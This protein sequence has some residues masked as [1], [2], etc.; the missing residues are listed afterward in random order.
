MAAEKN[1]KENGKKAQIATPDQIENSIKELAMEAFTQTQQNG[2][3]GVVPKRKHGLVWERYGN[4]FHLNRDTPRDEK[5]DV[6]VYYLKK[7]MTG[8]YLEKQFDEYTFPYKIYGQEKKLLDRILRTY[9]NTNGNLG[10]IFN[11][12]RG[13]GKTVSAKQLCNMF[14]L[15]VILVNENLEGCHVYVNGIPQDIVVFIDE[16]EKIFE[17]ESEMLTIMDGSI[18]SVYRRTFLLTTN[19]LYVNDNLIQRPGRIRYVKTFKDLTPE[20]TEELIDDILI[21]KEFKEPLIRFIANLEM[22]TIDIVKAIIQEV[23]IHAEAPDEFADIFNVRRLTGKFNVFLVDKNKDDKDEEPIIRAIGSN[24]K[25]YDPLD[26][27]YSNNEG[28]SL[29]MNG[30]GNFHITKS[31]DYNTVETNI[32][33]SNI[34]SNYH[35]IVFNKLIELGYRPI[36]GDDNLRKSLSS[37]TGKKNQNKSAI[38]AMN[39][40]NDFKKLKNLK[41]EMVKDFMNQISFQ[42]VI[43]RVESTYMYQKNFRKKYD[44]EYEYFS[45]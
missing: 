31:L 11:G 40:V 28:F 25:S 30:L 13:T 29:S 2:H 8:F 1:N 6:G 5:L 43:V 26:Y 9:K 36:F 24:F 21:H 12:L 39:M 42:N 33:M 41:F 15:P 38:T 32:Y 45:M 23:N 37:P 35:E 27:S 18:N 22:I 20:I 4:N 7:S 44:S 17:K 3:N 16:Y 10:A 19:T 34:Y 14:K